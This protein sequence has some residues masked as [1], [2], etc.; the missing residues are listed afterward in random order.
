MLIKD[1][2][3]KIAKKRV[4]VQS[5]W[6]AAIEPLEPMERIQCI[7]DE[8]RALENQ[9]RFRRTEIAEIERRM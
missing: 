7:K 4:K 8:I 3:K 1:E 6:D 2:F 5:E 9:I